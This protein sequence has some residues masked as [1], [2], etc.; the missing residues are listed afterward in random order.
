MKR[1]ITR[2]KKTGNFLSRLQKSPKIKSVK[3]RIRKKKSE[4]QKL[5]REYR[6]KLKSESRRLRKK[7]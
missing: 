5:S 1:K 7:K 6:S 4:L 3:A 2:R